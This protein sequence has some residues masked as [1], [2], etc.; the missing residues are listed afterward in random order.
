MVPT[1]RV[2]ADAVHPSLPR[3]S[4]FL[5]FSELLSQPNHPNLRGH[6]LAAKII[7]RPFLK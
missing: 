5:H 1:R 2:F 4:I 7:S 3:R 6:T